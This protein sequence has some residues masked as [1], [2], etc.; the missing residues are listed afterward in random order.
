MRVLP[1]VLLLVCCAAMPAFAA[2]AGAG[3][4][5]VVGDAVTMISA[6]RV[7]WK[8]SVTTKDTK[9]EQVTGQAD[10]LLA[11]ALAIG[12][13]LGLAREQMRIRRVSVAMRYE[14]K[15][16]EYTRKFSHYEVSQQLMF[17]EEDVARYDEF[18]GAL[19]GVPGLQVSQEF[20]ATCAAK[21]R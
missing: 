11:Q 6:D 9:L 2:G 19:T 10:G 12:E 1:F 13:S 20:V 5:T 8:L 16:G 7:V 3:T 15:G 14:S 21:G 4:I 17:V 18:R